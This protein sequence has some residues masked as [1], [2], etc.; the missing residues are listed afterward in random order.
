MKFAD[1]LLEDAADLQKLIDV[2]I[3]REWYG[4]SIEI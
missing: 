4:D 1:K 3:T 2:E